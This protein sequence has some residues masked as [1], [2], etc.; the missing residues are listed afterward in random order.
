MLLSDLLPSGVCRQTNTSFTL[1]TGLETFVAF[2]PVI[3]FLR[4]G[5]HLLYFYPLLQVAPSCDEAWI[6]IQK[7]QK[8]QILALNLLNLGSLTQDKL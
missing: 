6:W 7:T 8:V 2:F 5:R 3:F 1:C 4:R